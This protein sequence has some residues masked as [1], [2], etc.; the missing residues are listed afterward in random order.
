MRLFLDTNVLL[1]GYFQRSG[2]AASNAVIMRCDRSRDSGWIA[3]HSLS[4]AYY[5]VRG[6]SRSTSTALQYINDLLVWAE[7]PQ[8]GRGDALW[9]VQSGL[10]DFEDALQLAAAACCGADVL[11][12]RNTT[13]FKASPIPVMTPEEFLAAHP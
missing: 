12:T 5:L 6:H 3:W 13:D 10:S 7:V 1:D 8:T 9:A 2:A 11:I 4:N